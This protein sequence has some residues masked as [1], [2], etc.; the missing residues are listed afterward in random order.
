MCAGGCSFL[1]DVYVF[2]SWWQCEFPH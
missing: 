1:N 2:C